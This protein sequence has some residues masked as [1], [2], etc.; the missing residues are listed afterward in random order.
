MAAT[1]GQVIALLELLLPE[2]ASHHRSAVSIHAIC[3]VLASQADPGS[4]PVLQ[5]PLIHEIPLL[6][7]SSLL[8]TTVLI[9]EGRE[10]QGDGA[11]KEE[12]LGL[13]VAANSSEAFAH[14]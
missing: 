8:S 5:L 9:Q 6:H 3:E 11:K 10:G 2:I 13:A 12:A 4:L 7:R 14:L 1:L